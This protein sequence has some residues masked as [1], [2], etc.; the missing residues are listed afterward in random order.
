MTSPSVYQCVK[1]QLQPTPEQTNDKVHKF[2]LGDKVLVQDFR[3]ISTSKWQH[4]TI[5]A[6]CSELI[7]KV[8]CE[9]HHQQVHIDQPHLHHKKPL[10]RILNRKCGTMLDL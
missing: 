5:T 9:G 8:D 2:K 7:Y 3:L 10:F 4:G 6:E 1:L